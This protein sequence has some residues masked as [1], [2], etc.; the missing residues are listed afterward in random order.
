MA[1]NKYRVMPLRLSQNPSFSEASKE[2][3]RTLLALIEAEGD[4]KSEDVLAAMAGVSV[5]RCKAALAF[6]EECGVIFPDDGA[7]RVTEEFADRLV[8]GEID[9]RPTLAVAEIGRAPELQSR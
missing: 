9:E 2:E 5:A 4:M 7:P 1:T 3:L 6:W 8:R